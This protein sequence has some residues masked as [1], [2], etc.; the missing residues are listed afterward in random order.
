[1][2]NEENIEAYLLDYQEGNLSKEEKHAV[3]AYVLLHPE[4]AID[5]LLEPLP[6]DTSIQFENKSSLKK[7]N[8]IKPAIF[9]DL[10]ENESELF[11]VAKIENQLTDAEEIHFN[12]S[13]H[14]DSN[15]AKE[16]SLY[17]KTILVPN[18]SIEFNE[19]SNLKHLVIQSR[20]IPFRRI[21]T[22]AAAA[23]LL[24]FVG[25]SI[26]QSQETIG[27]T[28]TLNSQ[29]K[30]PIKKNKKTTI[31]PTDQVAPEKAV[32]AV[33]KAS[34][35][36]IKPTSTD[37]I[38]LTA[39]EIIEAPIYTSNIVDQKDSIENNNEPENTI[40]VNPVDTTLENSTIA[41]VD[42]TITVKKYFLQKVNEFIFGMKDPSEEEKYASISQRISS[43]SGISFSFGKR[44]AK[45]GF[46]LKIGKL[47]IERKKS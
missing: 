27:T 16:Y 32:F 36:K 14:S 45:K 40:A 35:I 47:S 1:M 3:E 33:F 25:Y 30:K 26:Y 10:N 38:E 7:Q 11:L 34:P 8:H 22:Y 17:Y 21:A 15:F 46:H 41:K 23:S 24:F 19:K 37:T 18:T 4:F 6:L 2:I 43:A 12:N 13:L 5:I 39:P 42:G 31:L 44:K 28:S 20:V 9:S 29:T